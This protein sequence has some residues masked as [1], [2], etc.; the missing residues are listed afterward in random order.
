MF[1][2]VIRKVA[3]PPSETVC[4]FGFFTIWIAGCA[5]G[6]GGFSG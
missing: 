3:V 2:T 1:A 4:S 6:V 5:T